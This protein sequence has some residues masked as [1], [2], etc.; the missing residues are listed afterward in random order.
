[1]KKIITLITIILFSFIIVACT[2]DPVLPTITGIQENGII[3]VEQGTQNISLDGITATDADGNTLQLRITGVYDLTQIGSYDVV[4]SATDAEGNKVSLN[5]KVQV[6]EKQLTELEK[7]RALYEGTIYNVDS[8]DNG[9]PNWQEDQIT[10]S[11]GF[12]YYVMEDAPN[13]VWLNIAKFM[14]KYPNITVEKDPAFESGWNGDDELLL[15]QEAALLEGKLPDVFFNPKGAESYDKGMT[16]DLMPYIKT[17]EEAEFITPNALSG[18]RTFDNL[19]I[20]GIPWQGVGPMVALNLSLLETLGIDAPGYDWTYAEYE[21]LRAQIGT[22]SDTGACVFPGVIDYSIFGPNYFDS[23]PNGYKGYNIE[24]QRFDLANA[25]NY[26]AWLE[27][28]ATEAKR[29]WHY[30]DLSDE[31]K[32]TRC[33]E[34]TNEWT[35]GVRAINTIMLYSFNDDVRAMVNKGWDIDIY[36]YPIAP[37]GG[38]TATYTY[39]DY[40]SVNRTLTSDRVKA[41]AAFQLLKWLTYGE[42][43]LENRWD[44]LYAETPESFVDGSLYLMNYVQG[45]PITSN[46]AVLAMHPLVKGFAT[47]SALNIFNFEAFKNVAFQYQ[48]SNANPYLRQIPAFA[49]VAN[50][51]DPWT[52]KDTMRDQSVSYANIIPGIEEQLND[53]IVEY[54]QYYNSTK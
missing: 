17:D 6:T 38:Q 11:F 7:A 12:S 8:D 50:A 20:W 4:L 48:M 15:L 14:E 37:E 1:M 19:E 9:V 35:D 34:I 23:V 21:A 53:D 52:L 5:I 33:P 13:P 41:E 54:L 51:F 16:L 28:N 25:T 31:V 26:G 29:G 22:V 42:E 18:M 10:L 40:L 49:S 47:D 2:S 45:W 46:P 32:A 30:F 3:A 43:G 44:L 39:H 36:P 27:Q 24:T